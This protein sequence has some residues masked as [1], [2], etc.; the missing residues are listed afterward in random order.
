ML[1][2]P[3]AREDD[4][5]RPADARHEFAA[6]LPRRIEGV[7]AA[8]RA[9]EGEETDAER[10]QALVRR[11][12]ALASGA[13]VLGYTSAAEALEEAE[14]S[15][16]RAQQSGQVS[17][18][19]AEV[20]RVLD[21]VPSLLLGAPAER[22]ETVPPTSAA[23]QRTR[24][25]H[26]L[27]FGPQALVEALEEE[28]GLLEVDRTEDRER[29]L[30]I[31]RAS[32]PDVVVVDAD[33]SDARALVEQ[34]GA[35]ALVE[36]VPVLVVGNFPSS[37]TAAAFV[38]LGAERVLPKPVSPDVLRRTAL[39]LCDHGVRARSEYP[40]VGEATVEELAERITR[41]FRRGLLD[42]VESGGATTRV[43]FG[44]GSDVLAA[45]WGAIARVRELVTLRS[46]G[47]VRF[48]PQGPEGAVPVAPW[49]PDER[50]AGERISVT[51]QRIDVGLRGRKV[52]V[53]DDDPAVVWFLADLLRAVGAEVFEAHDGQTALE[54]TLRVWPD[55]VISDVLMPE[56]DGFSLCHE[57]RRD[58]AVR[59]VPV[60]LLSWK[61][62]LLQRVRE[63]GATANG[64]LQKETAAST[65]LERVREVLVARARVEQRLSMGGEVR[66]RL[67]GFT[68]RLLL[69]IVCRTVPD[70]S[71][72]FRDAAY[73]HEV[74]VRDGRVRSVTR[75]AADGTFE[76]GA[77]LLA[78]LLGVSAGRF[79]VQPESSPCRREFDQPLEELL[80]EPIGQAR[81]ALAA[82]RAEALAK[83]VRVRI[84]ADAMGRYL[85]C[86]PVSVRRLIE[87]VQGGASPRDM[88]LSGEASLGMLEAALSDVARRGAI[89]AVER[90]DG[91]VS[92]SPPV[93]LEPAPSL[94][95]AVESSRPPAARS[96]EGFAPRVEQPAV[97][98]A[99][100]GSAS[101]LVAA[102]PAAASD[103][104][105]F[106]LELEPSERPPEV[107]GLPP[108]V[109]R[110]PVDVSTL[111]LGTPADALR[112]PADAGVDPQAEPMTGDV[113]E[114]FVAAAEADLADIEP[115]VETSRGGF[116]APSVPPSEATTVPPAEDAAPLLD[117]VRTESGLAPSQ[118]T[119]EVPTR[120]A[121]PT[122]SA[123][124]ESARTGEG[125]AE[126][127]AAATEVAAPAEASAASALAAEPP[128]EKDEGSAPVA[129]ASAT[130]E[131]PAS[132]KE[133]ASAPGA[134]E[135]V[136]RKQPE[137]SP[138]TVPAASA[139]EPAADV[140]TAAPTAADSASEA[141]AERAPESGRGSEPSREEQAPEEPDEPT[142]EARKEPAREESAREDR[143]ES[144]RGQP[145]DAAHEEPTREEPSD[146]ARDEP[147][148]EEEAAEEGWGMARTLVFSALAFGLAYGTVQWVIAPLAAPSEPATPPAAAA[149]PAPAK[150]QSRAEAV[151][152]PAPA[153]GLALETAVLDLEPGVEIGAD[154]GL[155][156]AAVADGDAIYV[157]GT[158]VGP[159][160]RRLVPT[161]P[162]QHEVKIVRRAESAT[163]RVEV[164]LGRRV[165]VS[166]AGPQP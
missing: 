40:P 61:E 90:E 25:A 59:D 115:A 66:G 140:A 72:S 91:P 30:E 158:L 41:E 145:S 121:P 143:D 105:A 155:I 165:R 47:T 128:S 76:R 159:G 123:L 5:T 100:L 95:V 6:S 161:A 103:S 124:T 18:A 85:E 48:A 75:S 71:V 104:I 58:V 98:A 148:Q 106:S 97:D 86:T 42:A 111:S 12:H 101:P 163:V 164:P 29:A 127:S 134:E 157:D 79:V 93:G 65:I 137:S 38:T 74:Q 43:A 130:G 151:A 14:E 138:D 82:V 166:S 94:A 144:T 28:G 117:T 113:A 16:E 7:R 81:A 129:V 49:V 60:I 1:G 70:A 36:R 64:Y 2:S 35:D 9:L 4:P 84:D 54:R 73:L 19:L 33:R 26:V 52:V 136:A 34:L 63:L 11:L 22:S 102:D 141:A 116:T 107:A 118:P 17:G 15:L 23:V 110:L 120:P 45:V 37:S 125:A 135:V 51:R 67:D 160:P 87:R 89:V 156:E 109:A 83:V 149:P 153:S 154:Q 80:A 62:D 50:A 21:L 122:E 57:V 53:A 24:P 162:G 68:P 44:D 10:G 20:A 150:V 132:G 108:E 31:L 27:V 131:E 139:A 3:P 78:S 147:P 77:R 142:R 114:A 152:T 126:P 99:W 119:S 96:A 8:M 146:E 46:G 88:L 56:R 39:E 13:R 55:L 69:E 112:T 92:L 133:A 32:G